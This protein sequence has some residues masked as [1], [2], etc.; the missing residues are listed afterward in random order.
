[1][2]NST[3]IAIL[4]FL[5]INTLLLPIFNIFA[6]GEFYWG[7][8]PS[9]FIAL[10]CY[11]KEEKFSQE[12]KVTEAIFKNN[13]NVFENIW[14]E[15]SIE[16]KK[17]LNSFIENNNLFLK[18]LE[19]RQDELSKEFIKNM[20]YSIDIAINETNGHV[21]N[22]QS[23]LNNSI[24]EL[25]TKTLDS[26][27]KT[28]LELNGLLKV[29]FQ[30]QSSELSGIQE[31]LVSSSN[32]FKETSIKNQESISE[33]Q[34]IFLSN[35]GHIKNAIVDS[36][37]SYKVSLENMSIIVGNIDK[38]QENIKVE[39]AE[40]ITGWGNILKSS[41]R[42]FD[43]TVNNL[44]EVLTDTAEKQ[45]KNNKEL[46]EHLEENI[47][48]QDEYNSNFIEMQKEYLDSINGLHK[49]DEELISKLLKL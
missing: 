41:Y 20:K 16:N 28:N 1:M 12:Q 14:K 2:K 32:N 36:N 23:I 26:F 34:S 21:K 48:K 27:S 11:F 43:E 15:S 49:T 22:L 46:L 47:E 30:K 8:T 33:I 40:N 19:E 3:L 42:G 4:V 18:N 9:F 29:S 37:N 24:N 5:G 17:I 7:I 39:F 38:H 45:L 10:G 35:I 6:N 25:T 13:Q 44:N 31:N